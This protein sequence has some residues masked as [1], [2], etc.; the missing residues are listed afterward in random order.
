MPEL[1]EVETVRRGLERLLVGRRCS[2]LEVLHPGSF[3][4]AD[5][6]QAMG[7]SVAGLRRLGKLL[8]VDLDDGRCLA[9]HLKMTGQLVF[10]DPAAGE[11]FGAGH[12]SDSLVDRLPDRSTRVI[13]H[14]GEAR[15]YFNDQRKFGWIRLLDAG[16]LAGLDFVKRLGPEPLAAGFSAADFAAR[17]RARPGSLVKAAL[18]DQGVVAGIGNIYADEALWQAAVHPERRVRDLSDAELTALWTAVRAVMELSISLGGSTDRNYVDAEGKRGAYLDFARVFRRQGQPCARCGTLLVKTRVAGRG[19][20]WCPACQ[21][22]P[23][24]C[25]TG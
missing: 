5:A 4:P 20:H 6:A 2:G 16:G 3:P 18:L 13:F 9:V 7:R 15:L 17:L 12:P 23:T 19:S 10:V 1:P 22:A 14:F 8:V 24:H 25:A 11:R 21:R